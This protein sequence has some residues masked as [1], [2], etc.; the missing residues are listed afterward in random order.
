MLEQ[1]EPKAARPLLVEAQE[2]TTRM[3]LANPGPLP[4]AYLLLL[5]GNEGQDVPIRDTPPLAVQAEAHAVLFRLGGVESHLTRARELLSEMSSHLTAGASRSF[6][7]RNMT[8]RMLSGASATLRGPS[9]A[10]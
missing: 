5:D 1:N 2:I 3:D 6:W 10:V 7:S 8:A 4:A 9:A